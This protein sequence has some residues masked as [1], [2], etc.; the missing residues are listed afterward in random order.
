MFFSVVW[1]AAPQ[2]DTALCILDTSVGEEQVHGSTCNPGSIEGI[3][4]VFD[5]RY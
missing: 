2:V 3:L 4:S 5:C 1:A